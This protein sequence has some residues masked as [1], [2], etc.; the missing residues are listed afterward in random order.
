MTV[1]FQKIN[2]TQRQVEVVLPYSELESLIHASIKKRAAHQHIPGFR[3]G[4]APLSM[5]RA[6]LEGSVREEESQRWLARQLD[7]LLEN[8]QD[9]E[10]VGPY[11]IHNQEALPNKDVKYI[12]QFEVIPDVQWL[13]SKGQSFSKNQCDVTTSDAEKALQLLLLERGTW[14]NV[15]RPVQKGDRI[16]L[17]FQELDAEGNAKD[18]G[19]S[20][21]WLELNPESAQRTPG[22]MEHLLGLTPSEEK[23][24]EWSLNP[25]EDKKRY[26]AQIIEIKACVPAEL[27]E[28]FFE[29]MQVKEHSKEAL[30][31]QIHQLMSLNVKK[32]LEEQWMETVLTR[33]V[34][35]HPM[36]V[37]H[38]LIERK[39]EELLN[40]RVEQW[41]QEFRMSTDKVRK[42]IAQ[43]VTQFRNSLQPQAEQSVRR[44]ILIRHYL[45]KESSLLANEESIRQYIEELSLRYDNPQ[46]ATDEMLRD[47]R[48]KAQCADAL[49]LKNLVAHWLQEATVTEVSK[50][51][52]ELFPAPFW[53][54]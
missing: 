50:G 32:T 37:P 21:M 24:F 4:A 23:T 15:E 44:F 5:V 30:L 45:K 31:K 27:N 52:F 2:D 22:L 40:E 25:E 49:T 36:T 10:R 16:Q 13:T 12:V 6:R 3:K 9:I 43:N 35:L 7:A 8:A 33:M 1:Q 39:T 20:P 46:E 34:E 28:A 18:E 38:V 19:S 26:R 47:S 29:Q 14:S 42:M 17:T 53:I 54:D 48:V 51:Y 41:A 11:Q